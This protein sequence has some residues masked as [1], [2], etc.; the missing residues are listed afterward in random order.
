[1]QLAIRYRYLCDSTCLASIAESVASLEKRLLSYSM[2]FTIT[3][4]HTRPCSTADYITSHTVAYE[5]LA[6]LVPGVEKEKHWCATKHSVTDSVFR[7]RLQL[8]IGSHQTKYREF[9]V[10]VWKTTTSIYNESWPP[11]HLVRYV[12]N[13]LARTYGLKFTLPRGKHK[14][15]LLPCGEFT[16]AGK[17]YTPNVNPE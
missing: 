6:Q 7:K 10:K 8:T 12:N 13:I 14:Y 3:P 9:M 17:R 2:P 1:M 11:Q 4:G 5:L 15:Q 16:W